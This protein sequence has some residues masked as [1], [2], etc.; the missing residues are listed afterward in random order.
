VITDYEVVTATHIAD[1][2][3]RVREKIKAGWRP[4]GGIALLHEEEAGRNKPHMV[5]AQA[6][7]RAQGLETSEV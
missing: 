3:D 7:V 6:V 5:F 2:Q 1:L 4:I